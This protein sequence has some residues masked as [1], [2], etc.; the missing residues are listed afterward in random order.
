MGVKEEMML[1]EISDTR[2]VLGRL[3]VF[4]ASADSG[5]KIEV[6]NENPLSS[7]VKVEPDGT[8]WLNGFYLPRS[9]LEAD[10][11]V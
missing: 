3:G 5:V 2:Q 6:L 7:W 9:L 11:V 10:K 1:G 8:H 4:E